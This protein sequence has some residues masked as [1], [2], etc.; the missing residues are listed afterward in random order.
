MCTVGVGIV[1]NPILIAN[2]VSTNS[3]GEKIIILWAKYLKEKRALHSG[4]SPSSFL[5]GRFTRI[6]TE[7][8]E[9]PTSPVMHR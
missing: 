8:G 5:D 6:A 2:M 9:H 1:C 4:S 7:Y 3:Q